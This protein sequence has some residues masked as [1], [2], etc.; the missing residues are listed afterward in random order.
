[1][2]KRKKRQ[3]SFLIVLSLLCVI[4]IGSEA[5]LE[6]KINRELE[7]KN[8]E[9]QKILDQN[10]LEST[11]KV[12]NAEDFLNSTERFKW[13]Y[14]E[15]FSLE[16]LEVS[17]EELNQLP[18]Y[19]IK[20]Q[21]NTKESTG[22]AAEFFLEAPIDEL[23]YEE[24]DIPKIYGSI[25]GKEY[26]YS[27]KDG[28]STYRVRSE[29]YFDMGYR[30]EGILDTS[31]KKEDL[32]GYIE[33][34]I[35]EL[36]LGLWD[37]DTPLTEIKEVGTREY[38]VYDKLAMNIHCTSWHY[39]FGWDGKYYIGSDPLKFGFALN[40]ELDYAALL[41]S[42]EVT[43]KAEMEK[44]YNT[45]EDLEACLE[46]IKKGVKRNNAQNDLKS[47]YTIEKVQIRYCFIETKNIAGHEKIVPILELIGEETM[48]ML[49]GAEDEK[50]AISGEVAIGFNLDTG[51]VICTTTSPM[52]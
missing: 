26:I 14:S 22:K 47:W 7:E 29:T 23:E 9:I 17:L 19:R 52:N 24:I 27:K 48:E 20:T 42:H 49:Q 40:G 5:G 8:R 18:V 34:C 2:Q 46:K 50:A 4:M 31:K 37:G 51:D 15:D 38:R 32:E 25:G 35:H 11:V 6:V 39:Q 3:K 36:R 43:E 16:N 1:M 21:P 45:I 28:N 30:R 33:T 13:E 41:Y 44:Q 10:A 12:E